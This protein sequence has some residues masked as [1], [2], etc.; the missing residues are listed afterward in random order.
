MT[1]IDP[2]TVP[3]ELAVRFA[4]LPSV[5][6]VVLSGSTSSRVDDGSSDFD[7]YV[8]TTEEIPVTW[9]TELAQQVEAV[10]SAVAPA[11]QPLLLTRANA[12]LDSLDDLLLAE[13]LT[14]HRLL[15]QS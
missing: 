9:R 12:L 10:V 14:R 13:G 2:L 6:A 11:S 7:I 1:P 8:Y 3:Q 15:R 4:E 5:L